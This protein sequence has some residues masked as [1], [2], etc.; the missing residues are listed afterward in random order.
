MILKID[1]TRYGL[2]ALHY[3]L[4]FGGCTPLIHWSI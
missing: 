2:S 3:A 1:A 4:V